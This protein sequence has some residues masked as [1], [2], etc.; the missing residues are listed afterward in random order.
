MGKKKKVKNKVP[1]RKYK[2]YKMV[3]GK[4]KRGKVCPKCG[5]G[6][7]L[8]EHKDR[9]TCGFCGYCEFGTKKQ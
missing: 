9:V 3:D 8:G 4:L 7:F 5:P 1:S 2:K 6:F